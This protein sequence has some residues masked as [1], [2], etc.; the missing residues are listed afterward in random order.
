MPNILR[1]I[2]LAVSP[3]GFNSI[4]NPIKVET[5]PKTSNMILGRLNSMILDMITI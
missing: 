4:V 2:I 5:R 1:K 3:W